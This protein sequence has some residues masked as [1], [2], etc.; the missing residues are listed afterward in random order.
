MRPPTW[1]ASRGRRGT[2]KSLTIANLACHLAATGKRVLITSQKDKALEVVDEKLR[3]LGLAELPMT[4]LRRDKES[5]SELLGR[6]ERIEKR[7]TTEEVE[8]HYTDLSGTLAAESDD[9]V[10]DA[11]AYAN[12]PQ[13]GIRD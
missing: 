11:R 8:A 6:L 4:L 3:E 5:K 2:G 1:S 12:S 7:R 10:S 13:V 9:Q